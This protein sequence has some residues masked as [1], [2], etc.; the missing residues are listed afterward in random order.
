MEEITL[1]FSGE[2]AEVSGE[3]M[4]KTMKIHQLY[5]SGEREIELCQFKELKLNCS[6]Q[7]LEYQ[8]WI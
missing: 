7:N 2:G 4:E 6:A 8:E 1:S 5:G 3:R